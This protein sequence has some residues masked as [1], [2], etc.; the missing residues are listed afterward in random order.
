MVLENNC[1]PHLGIIAGRGRLPFELASIYSSQGGKCCI[2]L[3]D[4]ENSNLFE[5]FNFKFFKLGNVG[6]L[7][8]YFKQSNIKNIVFAG[9]VN[10]P[11]LLSI[12]VDFIGAVLLARILK[13]QI[14][15]DDRLLRIIAAFFEEK[16]FKVISANEILNFSVNKNEIL[17]TSKPTEQDNNDIELGKEVA[18]ILGKL[19][20]GQSII[21]ED[22]Y[23][24]GVEAAEGTDNLI[25]RCATFRK[26]P[27]G[28][29]LIK[30][31]KSAQDSRLDI[32]TIGPETI[33]NLAYY[34]YKGLAI[35][36][37]K[38]IILEPEMTLKLANEAQIF[39]INI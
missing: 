26:K 23:V 19:D 36:K 29:I 8:D 25:K 3:L 35:Q 11:N 34:K 1:L 27:M 37:N 31:M 33:R 5:S 13:Y 22:G 16:G 18:N 12:K 38:V 9:G 15:G 24:I 7:I 2:A 17:T 14:L 10:R 20:I 39:I 6:A 21:V 4:E 28:G 32:P 30:M